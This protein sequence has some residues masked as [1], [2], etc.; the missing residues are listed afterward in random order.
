MLL[1]HSIFLLLHT[2]S[3]KLL[4]PNSP[5]LVLLQ[6]VDPNMLTGPDHEEALQEGETGA[7]LL[8]LLAYLA[9]P[10]SSDCFNP[11]KPGHYRMATHQ[12]RRQREWLLLRI[13]TALRPFTM[14]VTLK[15]R[16]TLT[17]FSSSW[18][19]VRIRIL[20]IRRE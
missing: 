6:F 2:D 19:M 4:W 3:E 13:Q 17:L 12:T 9:D 18:K 11:R 20:R 15:R 5:L 14:H 16:P 8:H 7:T 10:T 1:Y